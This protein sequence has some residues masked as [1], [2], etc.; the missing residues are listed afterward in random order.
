MAFYQG[1]DGGGGEQSQENRAGGDEEE[2]IG[3]TAPADEDGDEGIDQ[4]KKVLD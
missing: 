2:E 4:G 3:K 1:G